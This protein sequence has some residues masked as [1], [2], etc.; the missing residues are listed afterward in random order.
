ML[1]EYTKNDPR[2]GSRVDLEKSLA[3]AKIAAGEAVLVETASKK[4]GKSDADVEAEE[5]ATTKKPKAKA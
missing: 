5:T 4:P 1:I 3:E 2:S